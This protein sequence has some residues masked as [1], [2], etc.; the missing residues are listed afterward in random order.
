MLQLFRKHRKKIEDVF[1]YL[2]FDGLNKG[3]PFI[4]MAMIAIKLSPEELGV[5]STKT[6]VFV[7]LNSLIGMG[8]SSQLIVSLR[9]GSDEI[10][11]V[12]P[13]ILS[14]FIINFLI[15]LFLTFIADISGF[16]V[17]KVE[18][19]SILLAS[20]SFSIVQIQLSIYQAS[21]NARRF[22]FLNLVLSVLMSI[23][24]YGFVVV[25]NSQD[26]VWFY[27]SLSYSFVAISIAVKLLSGNSNFSLLMLKKFYLLGLFQLPHLLSNW[28][29]LGFDRLILL[30][31]VNSTQLGIY[32][33]YLQFGLII[34]TV[35]QSI[36]RYWSAYLIKIL[37]EN[38]SKK[39]INAKISQFCIFS[40]CFSIIVSS[41]SFFVIVEFFPVV[42]HEDLYI[43]FVIGAAYGC[44]GL[45]FSIV[46][47]IFYIEK[48]YLLNIASLSSS[49]FHIAF[50]YFFIA[51]LDFGYQWAAYSLLFSWLINFFITYLVVQ[52]YEK[53]IYK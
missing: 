19:Y 23:C 28:V 13:S 5:Y 34:S 39:T 27:I 18:L 7:F 36:N 16:N 45:Y 17:K 2:F 47:I 14:V 35:L 32:S 46:N 42:Y 44:Q 41:I 38:A 40:L 11:S 21:F 20:L 10:K 12:I 30:K 53:K 1:T 4:L 48:T 50:S 25:N 31:F 52:K 3:L 6:I 43:V 24:I 9:K 33:L 29:K 26:Q 15:S 8:L 49:F 22:G 51:V 37:S